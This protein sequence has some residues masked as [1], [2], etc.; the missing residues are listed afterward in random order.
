MALPFAAFGWRTVNVQR[1]RQD[2]YKAVEN[3][4]HDKVMSAIRNGARWKIPDQYGETVLHM[5]V[6]KSCK[7]TH[8]QIKV[9][10]IL[11]WFLKQKKL[12]VDIKCRAGK[13]ALHIAVRNGMLEVVEYLLAKGA[14]LNARD[15]RGNRVAHYMIEGEFERYFQ[16][17]RRVTSADEMRPYHRQSVDFFDKML[18]KNIPVDCINKN[19]DTPLRM[20]VRRNLLHVLPILLEYTKDIKCR[21]KHRKTVLHLFIEIFKSF[22]H[23]ENV[24]KHFK[25]LSI[26]TTYYDKAL[27]IDILKM[28][29]EKGYS[30][31]A[32]DDEGNTPLHSAAYRDCPE[33]TEI[34]LQNFRKV[35][36]C[37]NN[38]NTILHI[39]ID[40]CIDLVNRQHKRE[41]TK[42]VRILLSKGADINKTNKNGYT[43]LQLAVIRS[44]PTITQILKNHGADLKEPCNGG[45]LLHLLSQKSSK[46]ISSSKLEELIGLL[47]SQGCDVNARDKYGMTPMHW[48]AQSRRNA[49][50]I[51]LMKCHANVDARELNV[52]RLTPLQMAVDNNDGYSIDT[53]VNV[54]ADVNAKDA[55]GKTALHLAVK[56]K[57][58]LVKKLLSLGAHV[59]IENDA[60]SVPLHYA[61]K[62]QNGTALAELLKYGA[63][64]NDDG[65]YRV[66]VGL[67]DPGSVLHWRSI[68]EHWIKMNVAGLPVAPHYRADISAGSFQD[69]YQ[70]CLKEI[71]DLKRY[72]IGD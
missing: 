14:D 36:I 26:S 51:G 55:T 32:T 59:D 57:S 9:I 71:Q 3:R 42:F 39:V 13:T 49:V 18:A 46:V 1:Y 17:C 23:S 58:D 30:A 28:M 47:V 62:K 41:C 20:A 16:Y 12:K 24:P 7:E 21:D 31:S 66:L 54:G 68:L 22:N 11:E 38:G 34:M 61:I 44:N 40:N 37:N 5:A 50:I 15:G 70:D 72:E 6:K 8:E 29:L 67:P 10:R 43:P 4:D 25:V 2:L 45:N 65:T 56:F 27:I 53:L 52:R 60:K 69:L 63:D 64:V 19:R 35:N 48:A 33:L